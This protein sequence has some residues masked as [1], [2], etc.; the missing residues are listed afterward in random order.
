MAAFYTL[1]ENGAKLTAERAAFAHVFENWTK[2]TTRKTALSTRVQERG[3]FSH[4]L[5]WQPAEGPTQTSL[6]SSLLRE[7][8]HEKENPISTTHGR[9]Y[10][11]SCT[12][13]PN[14]T[15]AQKHMCHSIAHVANVFSSDT[16]WAKT[17]M[18]QLERVVL[19]TFVNIQ[20]KQYTMSAARLCPVKFVTCV[21]NNYKPTMGCVVQSAYTYICWASIPL[22]A[23]IFI[24]TLHIY[25]SR[26]A[27]KLIFKHEEQSLSITTM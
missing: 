11:E 4:G 13:G 22:R 12:C 21:L 7:A 15:N 25:C 16:N 18:R 3:Q 5:N 14:I 27:I 17:I 23:S 20:R 26:V 2:F 10:L 19:M 24:P 8:I 1:F 6:S 9:C